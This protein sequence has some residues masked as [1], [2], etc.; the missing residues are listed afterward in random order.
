MPDEDVNST[1]VQMQSNERAP[2]MLD[3]LPSITYMM[4]MFSSM[5][6]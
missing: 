4:G 5:R 1:D 6:Y 3:K 2:R